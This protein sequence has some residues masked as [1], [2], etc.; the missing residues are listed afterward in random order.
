M[1]IKK[2]AKLLADKKVR[3]IEWMLI[4]HP[5]FIKMLKNSIKRR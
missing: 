3:K 5:K 1:S 2:I 4:S